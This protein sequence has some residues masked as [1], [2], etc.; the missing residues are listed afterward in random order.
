VHQLATGFGEEAMFTREVQKSTLINDNYPTVTWPTTCILRKLDG[1]VD[2]GARCAHALLQLSHSCS[3]L[4][5]AKWVPSCSRSY[6]KKHGVENLI[7]I[8]SLFNLIK[9]CL[10]CTWERR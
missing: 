2:R 7:Q 10:I 6:G 1:R 5:M 4:A 9:L 8:I 3:E